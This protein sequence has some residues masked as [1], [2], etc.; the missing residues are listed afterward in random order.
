MGFQQDIV[1]SGPVDPPL[2]QAILAAARG[3]WPFVR[4]P[5]QDRHPPHAC[6]APPERTDYLFASQEEYERVL[7]R[8][9]EVEDGLAGWSRGFPAVAFAFVEADCFGGTCLYGGQVCRDGQVVARQPSDAGGLAAL[10]QHVGIALA[11]GSFAPFQRGY[12]D[13]R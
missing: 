3:R 10:L 6:F 7:E 5:R 2:K 4:L 8:S 1:V 11:D 12:F 9:G 13:E